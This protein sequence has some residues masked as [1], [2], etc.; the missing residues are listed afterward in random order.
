[1][2]VLLTND[3]G[4]AADGL[5]AVRVALARAGMDVLTL[6]PDGN[7]SAT[8]HHTTIREPITL[9]RLPDDQLGERWSCTGSPVDCVRMG[10]LSGQFVDVDVVVSG[11]NHGVN[12]GEDVFYSGTVAAAIESVLLGYPALAVSQAATPGSTG[13]LS[14]KPTSFPHTEFVAWLTR[15]VASGEL[16]GG[17]LINLNL[18]AGRASSEVRIAD[19]G[20]RDWKATK[21]DADATSTEVV[22]T[23]P[24]ASDPPVIPD[25]MT[26]FAGIA[27]GCA[28]LTPVRVRAGLHDMAMQWR[29]EAPVG[30]PRA[31]AS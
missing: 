4:I 28:T 17:L 16:D 21:V 3:D 9:R 15:W 7:R 8:G 26:D 10:L 12:L 30:L 13:F 5:A 24:W 11:I 2:R 19:L 20:R 27:A 22:I 29:S 6:A 1:M 14:E 18:P 31:L 25:A 23:R